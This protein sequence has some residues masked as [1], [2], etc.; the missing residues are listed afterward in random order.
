MTTR[1]EADP[2]KLLATIVVIAKTPSPVP[3][4]PSS[5][6]KDSNPVTG[7]PLRNNRFAQNSFVFQSTGH[8]IVLSQN[9]ADIIDPRQGEDVGGMLI[10]Y[11][12]VTSTR[13]SNSRI[14][15]KIILTL[16]ILTLK[17]SFPKWFCCGSPAL[18]N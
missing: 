17:S 8:K 9:H 5:P 16:V 1:V 15:P 13:L 6:A 7:N 12:N 14:P 18:K 11:N 2:P 3:E 4:R 10:H